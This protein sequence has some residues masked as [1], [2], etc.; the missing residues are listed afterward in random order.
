MRSNEFI[1]GGATSVS[2]ARPSRLHREIA[3]SS[4][5][6]AASRC[7]PAR[8]LRKLGGTDAGLDEAEAARRLKRFGLNQIAQENRTGVIH[9]L[10]NRTK[11][12]LNALLLTLAV[13]SYFLGDV[14]AAIVIAAMVILSIVTAFIQEHRSNQAAAKLRALV[15]TTASVKRQGVSAAARPCKV[16][17]FVEIPMEKI[18]PGDLVALSAGDMI[19]ADL[20]VLS[21]K[22]LYVNQSALTGEAMP[23]EKSARAVTKAV[24]DPFNLPNICFMGGNVVSGYATGVI[25]ETGGSSYFGQL[26]DSIAGQRVQTSFEKGIDRFTWLM[27]RFIIVLVPSVLLINGISKGDWIEALLFALVL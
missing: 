9:E 18:V 19:P 8:A 23:V 25:V 10:I 12:P 13:I 22:D 26:A 14:R 2:A 20:R 1:T 5:L 3:I 24:D 27:I 11:N 6:L 15:K 4:E 16:D 7:D 17:G 21:A